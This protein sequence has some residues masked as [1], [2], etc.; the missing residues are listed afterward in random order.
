VSRKFKKCIITG[1]GGSAGSYLAE[2]ILNKDKKIKIYG[3][4]RSVGYSQYLKKIYN[5][6]ITL[7]KVDIANFEKTKKIISKIKPDL[8]FHLASNA[9]VKLSFQQPLKIVK[10]NVN[11]TINLLEAI[12]ELKINPLTI[13]C[14]TSEV[15]GNV[16]KNDFPILETQDMKPVNPYAVSKCFQDMISQ[17]YFKSYGLKIII[18]RMFSYSNPRRLNLFLTAFADQ[19]ARSEY[20][21]T[22]FKIKKHYLKHGNLKS[23]RSFID[24]DDAMSA[25]WLAA[26]KGKIGEIYNISGNTTLSIKQ[27]LNMFLLLSKIKITP[28]LD[29]NLLR[30]VDIMCQIPSVKKFKN[31]TGWKPI[32]SF[33]ESISKILEYRRKKI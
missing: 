19:I 22:K 20:L 11:I 27:V 10:N 26:K 23:I 4:F 32:V 30:P 5:N 8:I 29:R 12:R 24:I 18:T 2:Y 7:Y 33:K 25:Y 21:W 6:R 13:I 3:F 16:N 28:K 17:V 14:S 31:H 9:D 1:I 15:Y